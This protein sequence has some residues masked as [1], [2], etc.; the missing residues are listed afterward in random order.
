MIIDKNYDFT[1]DSKGYW[2]NFWERNDGLGSGKS[3]PDNVSLTLEC[4]T[5]FTLETSLHLCYI[6][7]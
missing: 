5:H 3:D 2:D 1:M 6:L 7:K 4:I